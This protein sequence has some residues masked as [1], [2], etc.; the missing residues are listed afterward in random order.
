MGFNSSGKRNVYSHRA[1]KFEPAP[2]P[3]FSFEPPGYVPIGHCLYIYIFSDYS[4]VSTDLEASGRWWLSFRTLKIV[5]LV[6]FVGFKDWASSFDVKECLW[7]NDQIFSFYLC[8]WNW[9]VLA[10]L[11]L[12]CEGKKEK[13]K[14]Q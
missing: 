10:L 13:G 11:A 7:I 9:L 3:P 8:S 2:A 5:L 12:C 4:I 6:L 14:I 1:L